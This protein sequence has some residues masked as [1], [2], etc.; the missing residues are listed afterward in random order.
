MSELIIS[1]IICTKNRFSDF[2]ETVR[3]LSDQKRLPDELVVV[4][5]SDD[6]IIGEYLERTF[7]PFEFHY[8]H[9]NPG[10][11]YQRNYGIQKSKGTLLYFFD[12][13]IILEKDYIERIAR[14]FEY[15]LEQ[16][17]GAVGGRIREF[18]PR[19]T[20]T[21]RSWLTKSIYTTANFIFLDT[22]LGN[23]KFRLSGMPTHPHKSA[24]S[25]YIEC[26]SG[27][28]MAFRREVFNL[29]KFDE[30]LNGY[31]LMEDADISKQILIAGYKIYYKASAILEHHTSP[32]DRME[33]ASLAEM[34][35]LNYVYLYNKSWTRPWPRRIFFYWV[36]IGM[37]LINANHP[38]LRQG[39]IRG[40]H[41]SFHPAEFYMQ[42]YL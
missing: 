8:Y 28:C 30:Y 17:I 35:V 11:T 6:T 10:L 24:V 29:V 25:K 22:R 31:C 18:I 1:V 39:I 41:R 3:S 38:P 42:F 34:K 20:V 32:R 4:D 33:L 15:D 40:I 9:T 21:F 19:S 13:D 12:D 27:C 23:G 14:V 2:K 5:A 26:L 37:L 16:K 36:L 7:L